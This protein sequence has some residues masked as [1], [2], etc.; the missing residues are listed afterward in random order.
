MAM[1]SPSK[2]FH[3]YGEVVYTCAWFAYSAILFMYFLSA[4]FRLK[5][6]HPLLLID[7]TVPAIVFWG[8]SRVIFHR[9]I[10]VTDEYLEKTTIL[11]TVRICWEKIRDVKFKPGSSDLLGSMEESDKVF[12]KDESGRSIIV[13]SKF[14][15]F[16]ELEALLSEALEKRTPSRMPN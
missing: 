8:L 10:T 7:L 14:E 11:G 9:V 6:Y 5:W 4:F 1:S 3:N 2:T 16:A 12:L 15:N 13:T